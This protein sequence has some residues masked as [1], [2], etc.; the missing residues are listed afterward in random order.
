MIVSKGEGRKGRRRIRQDLGYSRLSSP[1]LPELTIDKWMDRRFLANEFLGSIGERQA[2]DLQRSSLPEQMAFSFGIL[3]TLSYIIIFKKADMLT[4]F[5]CALLL[6]LFKILIFFCLT[7][8]KQ[9]FKII[10]KDV[11]KRDL[12]A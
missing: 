3:S 1:I 12:E 5:R 7:I 2:Q 6:L 10:K 11:S 9:Q 8:E 4:Y